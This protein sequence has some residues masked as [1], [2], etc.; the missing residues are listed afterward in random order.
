[1]YLQ[2]S[3]EVSRHEVHKYLTTSLIARPHLLTPIHTTGQGLYI[4]VYFPA[5]LSTYIGFV[6]MLSSQ[7]LVCLGNC[8]YPK[9]FTHKK[10]TGIFL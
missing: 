1:M 2:F 4:S 6:L 7:I 9:Y 3:W 10:I 5:T 8:C